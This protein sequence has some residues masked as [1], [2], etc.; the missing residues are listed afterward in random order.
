MKTK[1]LMFLLTALS[2]DKAVCYVSAIYS[3]EINHSIIVDQVIDT[4]Y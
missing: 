3:I 4:R 1:E 2:S